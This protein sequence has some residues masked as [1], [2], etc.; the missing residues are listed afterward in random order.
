MLFLLW[1]HLFILSG[2]ISPPFSSS[3]LSTYQSGEF[4]FQ[5]PIFLPFHAVYRVLKPRIRKYYPWLCISSSVAWNK[6]IKK[7]KKKKKSGKLFKYP[8]YLWCIVIICLYLSL[9]FPVTFLAEGILVQIICFTST[10]CVFHLNIINRKLFS[11]LFAV[12]R[13]KNN[14]YP[15]STSDVI[16]IQLL[17]LHRIN[18]LCQRRQWHPTPVLLPGE[19]HGWRSLGGCSPWVC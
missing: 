11:L 8:N 16:K 9:P 3:I 6:T 7:K 19:S 2:V 13:P 4:I 1:L 17:K 18:L 10:K 15:L 5:G 12:C 14:K